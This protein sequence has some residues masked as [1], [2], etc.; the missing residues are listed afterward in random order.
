[1][2]ERKNNAY[3]VDGNKLFGYIRIQALASW[4]KIQEYRKEVIWMSYN[5]VFYIKRKGSMYKKTKDK[6][7]AI[8]WNDPTYLKLYS[9]VVTPPQKETTKKVQKRLVID[10]KKSINKALKAR[11]KKDEPSSV[12]S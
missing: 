10:K 1:M 9:W 2:A 3:I 7:D 6:L 8:F 12:L 11:K 4:M 5:T